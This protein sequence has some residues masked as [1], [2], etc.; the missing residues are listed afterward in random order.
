MEVRGGNERGNNRSRTRIDG[1]K[2]T[3]GGR[4][5]ARYGWNRKRT[6]EYISNGRIG[7]GG[8]GCCRRSDGDGDGDGDSNGGNNNDGRGMGGSSCDMKTSSVSRSRPPRRG[9]R[10]RSRGT[11]ASVASTTRSRSGSRSSSVSISHRRR[12]RGERSGRSGGGG[13]V[14]DKNKGY[15]DG[16]KNIGVNGEDRDNRGGGRRFSSNCNGKL[17]SADSGM[18]REGKGSI[19]IP[20]ASTNFPRRCLRRRLCPCPHCH[21]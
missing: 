8:R 1:W 17:E 2:K 4:P 6:A 16:S 10:K 20:A 21:Y 9:G 11:A 12:L 7:G 5:T 14:R 3:R 15:N 18:R 19:P 13:G